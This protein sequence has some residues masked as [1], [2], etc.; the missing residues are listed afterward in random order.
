MHIAKTSGCPLELHPGLR[1]VDVG[2]W[3]GR[4]RSEV[5][6]EDPDAFARW[7][8]GER[9]A[10][11]STETITEAGARVLATL[12]EIA[13]AVDGPGPMVVVGH[14]LALQAAL[15]GPH[16]ANG[17]WVQVGVTAASPPPAAL[18]TQQP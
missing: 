16:L 17:A 2:G 6:A 12:G 15:N 11:G 8:R 10:P 7:R 1:E 13:S 4:L 3:E 5:Q 14:G 9:P 18:S